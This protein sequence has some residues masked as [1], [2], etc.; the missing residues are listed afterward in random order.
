MSQNKVLIEHLGLRMRKW[1]EAG[2][3]YTA[4]NFHNLCSSLKVISAIKI[5]KVRLNGN[6]K[7]ARNM[8]KT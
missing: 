6:V 1:K 7:H 5:R 8:I 3:T 4:R 2:E